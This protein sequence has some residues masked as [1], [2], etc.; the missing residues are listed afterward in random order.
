MNMW[1]VIRLW[2]MGVVLPLIAFAQPVVSI[3]QA[4]VPG[5]FMRYDVDDGI[6]SSM[7]TAPSSEPQVWDFTSYDNVYQDTLKFLYPYQT[8]YYSLFPYAFYSTRLIA[9]T[10]TLFVY[11]TRTIDSANNILIDEIAG[12]AGKAMNDSLRLA[13]GDSFYVAKAFASKK[14]IVLRLPIRLG[15]EVY[16]TA[17]YIIY[18]Y[19]DNTPKDMRI[20][21]YNHFVADAWGWLYTPNKDSF[22]VLRVYE[23]RTFAFYIKFLNWTKLGELVMRTYSF[24]DSVNIAPVGV[25]TIDIN[26]RPDAFKYYANITDS[27][28]QDT[29]ADQYSYELYFNGSFL[30][31]PI[32]SSEDIPE[33]I[34]I[35]SPDG[36]ILEE[37]YYTPIVPVRTKGLFIAEALW[38]NLII[39]RKFYA[40]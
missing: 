2:L 34:T 19:R 27:L 4:P 24:F 11:I 28:K 9:R 7:I 38:K 18:N 14:S 30:Y 29:I 40:F 5:Y 16:D 22:F 1:K 36:R 20:E 10:E 15:D 31:V 25:I 35:Y 26:G 12:I 3:K 8:P 23:E 13:L 33:R 37:H 6:D 17:E 39:R 32:L 21:V